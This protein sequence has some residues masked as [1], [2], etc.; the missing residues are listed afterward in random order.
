MGVSMS[1]T[2]Q[3]DL[4][5]LLQ[6]TAKP[7]MDYVDRSSTKAVDVSK[8]DVCF[9]GF[10]PMALSDG[11]A[12]REQVLQAK[13]RVRL[14]RE[15]LQRAAELEAARASE[16]RSFT[17]AE[18]NVWTYVVLDG[19]E[20]RIVKCDPAATEIHLPSMLEDKPVV[21]LAAD[22][23]S[24][25]NDIEVID[26]PD[27]V[28][29][30]GGGAFRG[31]KNLKRIHFPEKL[32]SFD[33]NWLRNCTSLE[34]LELPGHMGKIEPTIF[35]LS[36]LRELRVGSGT[37]EV[38]PGAFR[39]SKL[40][41]IEVD[42][43][44][45]LIKSDGRA[46]YS[47][48]GEIFIALAVPD[49]HCEVVSGC[50]A[51][52]KKGFSNFSCLRSVTLPETLE[53]VGDFAFAST[54]LE[55][56]TA[57]SSLKAIGERAFFRCTAL[58]RVEL[59]EGLVEVRTDAFTD[60]GVDE[61]RL[62]ASV[63]RLG[64]PLAAQTSLTYVG[65]GAT[66]TIE[67]G[68]THLVLDEEGCLYRNTSEGYVLDRMMNPEVEEYTVMHGVVSIGDEAFSGH[69]NL[70]KVMLP[71]GLAVIGR[72]AFKACRKLE[73][74]NIPESVEAIGDEAFL[75][76]SLRAFSIP[77]ALQMLGG[78]ALVTYGAHHGSNPTLH[79]LEVSSENKRFHLVDD[80]LLERKADGHA[81]LLLS[82]GTESAVRIPAEVDELAP[83]AFNG[84]SGVEELHLSEAIT[85]VGMRA[86]GFDGLVPRIVVDFNEPVEGHRCIELDFPTT[87]RS[88]QQQMLALSVPD[89]VDARVIYEHYDTAIINGSSFDA[90]H[91]ERLALYDQAVRLVKR[92]K[93]PLY[94]TDVNRTMCERVLKTSI[95]D[96]CVEAAKHDDR[97]LVDD[98]LNLGFIDNDNINEVIDRVG[99]VQDASMTGYLLEAKRERF[100]LASLDFDL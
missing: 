78:N 96:I 88:A 40:Q 48:D 50:R 68:S 55:S 19:V 52:A 62:P 70:R 67:K 24:F 2:N 81:R 71:E 54:S 34:R 72:R 45:P 33:V 64:N 35:D 39:N 99:A 28:V 90:L 11:T 92:L 6:N 97:R 32:G 8:L 5:V 12:T 89:H 66:F 13:K 1:F 27:S 65:E 77:A 74:V 23:C 41:L 76:T 9:G 47:F 37:S 91:A 7:S 3:V 20:V 21:A 4:S 42:D 79:E 56:F 43:S 73:D 26:I 87:D 75:D 29:S 53:I 86:L 95:A 85:A 84:V 44:N 49:E 61:L 100:G 80:M 30:V 18:G 36:S 38:E 63:E 69:P 14:R 60:T 25:L 93:D 98:L 10:T 22:A 15:A 17:D 58:K 83:Y 31:C 82:L 16:E 57:P 94:L 51:I 59:N 46:L